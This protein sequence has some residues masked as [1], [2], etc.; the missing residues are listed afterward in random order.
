[1]CFCTRRRVI[2]IQYGLWAADEA[3]RGTV[4]QLPCP[5]S[6]PLAHNAGA[7]GYQTT[8][9]IVANFLL[10]NRERRTNTGLTNSGAME[11]WSAWA[12]QC[13]RRRYCRYI[14]NNNINI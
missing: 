10:S 2:S 1:M 11:H 4:S 5:P 9:A 6:T 12:R 3:R 13:T 14:N 7:R 8:A